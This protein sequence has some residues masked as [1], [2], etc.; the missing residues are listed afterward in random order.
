MTSQTRLN[1]Y[2]TILFA[3]LIP[4]SDYTTELL[5]SVYMNAVFYGLALLITVVVQTI[6]GQLDL[7]HAIFV[8]HLLTCLSIFHLYGMRCV[9]TR[10]YY[11]VLIRAE[12]KTGFIRFVEANGFGFKMKITLAVQLF[13]VYGVFIPWALY[14]WIKD[15]RFGSQPEC[16]HLVKYVF[17]FVNVRATV[18]WLHIMFIVTLS[19]STIIS[20]LAFGFI[21]HIHNGSWSATGLRDLTRWFFWVVSILCVSTTLSSF[22]NTN[23]PHQFFRLRCRDS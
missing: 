8:M 4:Q 16:N 2:V 23:S 13:Q 22:D 11:K 3:A 14:V 10:I 18:G 19:T 17:F 9:S 7:Y 5:D 6:Q 21:S 20:L 1:F 12:K 15:S